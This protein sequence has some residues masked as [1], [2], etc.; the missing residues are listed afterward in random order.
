MAFRV[1]GLGLKCKVTSG[2]SISDCACFLPARI[3][4]GVSNNKGLQLFVFY[5]EDLGGPPTL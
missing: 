2:S 1:E 3:H 4:M 5:N